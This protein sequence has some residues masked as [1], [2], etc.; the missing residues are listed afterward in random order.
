MSCIL[1]TAFWTARF[2]AVVLV[3]ARKS[4]CCCF[5]TFGCGYS[6]Y[7]R[8]IR[9]SNAAHGIEHT[10][11]LEILVVS[12]DAA[13]ALAELA[14]HKAYTGYGVYMYILECTYGNSVHQIPQYGGT[15]LASRQTQRE[16]RLA[17]NKNAEGKKRSYLLRIAFS[18]TKCKALPELVRNIATEVTQSLCPSNTRITS[19]FNKL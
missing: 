7:R 8:S 3:A 17:W 12:I 2:V 10:A 5:T 13:A 6:T 9:Q 19:P 11:I 4:R 14:A 18:R 1:S 15:I 16:E